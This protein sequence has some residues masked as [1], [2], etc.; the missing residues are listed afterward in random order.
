MRNSP[1]L[2]EE[3]VFSGLGPFHQARSGL[4]EDVPILRGNQTR[5]LDF[6]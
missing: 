2:P 6:A 3:P 1:E 5:Q 4:G